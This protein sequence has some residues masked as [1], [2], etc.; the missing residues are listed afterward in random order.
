MQRGVPRRDVIALLMVVDV[1]LPVAIDHERY[2]PP[3]VDPLRCGPLDR[4]LYRAEP[5]DQRRRLRVQADEEETAPDLDGDGKQGELAPREVRCLAE[6]RRVVERAVRTVAPAVI[7]AFDGIA[8]PARLGQQL[9]GSVPADIVKGAQRAVFGAA[10]E[11]REAGG[12]GRHILT[13]LGD[14]RL[15]PDPEPVAREDAP[16]FGLVDLGIRVP[17]GGQR[18]HRRRIHA[19]IGHSGCVFGQFNSTIHGETSFCKH[20]QSD[21]PSHISHERARAFP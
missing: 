17:A 15:A 8:V 16:P 7:G 20:G 21:W 14:L 2:F 3:E 5:L 10:Y 19:R 1:G 4:L 18:P 6:Q 12:G 11:E 9:G 13:R